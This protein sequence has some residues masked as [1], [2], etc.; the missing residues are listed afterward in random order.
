[1]TKALFLENS[2]RLINSAFIGFQMGAGG[3]KTF[4]QYLQSLGLSAD[5]KPRDPELTEITAADAIAKAEAI[6]ERARK[7]SDK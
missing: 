3:D 4:Q 2:N 6:L 1:M 5:G 7:G